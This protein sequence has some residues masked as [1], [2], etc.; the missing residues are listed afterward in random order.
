M[1][2]ALPPHQHDSHRNHADELH[3]IE[4]EAK[5]H[6]SRA[7]D[8]REVNR[9]LREARHEH[10]HREDVED[11]ARQAGRSEPQPARWPKN[12]TL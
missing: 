12:N 10:D 3:G 8:E 1:P 7:L 4:R 9:G 6:G 2:Q 11:G 5:R